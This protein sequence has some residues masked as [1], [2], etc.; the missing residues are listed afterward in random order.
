MNP[1]LCM[2][3]DNVTGVWFFRINNDFFFRLH[4]N[5]N[6]NKVFMEGMRSISRTATY[7]MSCLGSITKATICHCE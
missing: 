3:C 7:N 5:L 6:N 1:L 4:M 2:S